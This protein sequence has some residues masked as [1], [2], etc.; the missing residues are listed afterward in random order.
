MNQIS[1]MQQ[2]ASDAR[3]RKR[4][5]LNNVRF[6]VF[7]LLAEITISLMLNGF[8]L[9]TM[10]A[11]SYILVYLAAPTCS[12]VAALLFAYLVIYRWFVSEKVK[13]YAVILVMVHMCATI[14]WV[15]YIFWPVACAF[16]IPICFSVVFG[17]AAMTR[18]IAVLSLIA[19]ATGLIHAYHDSLAFDPYFFCNAMIILILISASYIGCI[20]LL[21]REQE[22][23]ECL[24]KT[25]QEQSAMEQQSMHDHLTQLYNQRAYQMLAEDAIRKTD[26]SQGTLDLAIVDI[27]NF[28]GV[29]ESWGHE[30]GNT[31]LMRLGDLLNTYCSSIGTVF[32]H[33]GEEF[34]VIFQDVDWEAI[35]GALDLTRQAFAGTRFAELH[36]RPVTFSAG[37]ARYRSGDTVQ[38]LFTRAD[39]AMQQ[40]KRNGC[41][42]INYDWH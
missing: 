34:V 19:T 20:T 9:R 33:G 17:D 29:N 25:L 2:D 6:A 27:D 21:E 26:D 31:V 4:I 11:V 32:R 28:R 1:C 10:D 14:W 41:N 8:G 3:W 24:R 15:H 16:V 39:R 18:N 35:I 13:N 7:I 22:K 37:I 5:Y 23:R 36:N 38:T 12:N 42:Q 40:V 30:A